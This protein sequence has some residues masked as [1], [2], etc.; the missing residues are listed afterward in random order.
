[1]N[2]SGPGRTHDAPAS[3]RD[4]RFYPYEAA[5]GFAGP[6]RILHGA[7]DPIVPTV[8]TERYR[9]VYRGSCQLTVRVGADHGFATVPDRAFLIE[10]VVAFIL[11]TATN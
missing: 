9:E 1:M 10:E 2:F 3:L 11:A 5:R 8:Y 4:T 7:S 6:V